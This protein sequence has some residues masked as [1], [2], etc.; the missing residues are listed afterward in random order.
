MNQPIVST[1]AIQ[2]FEHLDPP[3]SPSRL[4]GPPREIHCSSYC[5]GDRVSDVG[6]IGY[7]VRVSSQR[8]D[9]L[10]LGDSSEV[11]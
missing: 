7:I 1:L 3:K 4:T 5:H 9:Q 6:P 10:S 11:K 8:T 2:V